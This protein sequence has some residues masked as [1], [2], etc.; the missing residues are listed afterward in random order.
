MQSPAKTYTNSFPGRI[1][2]AILDNMHK[3]IKKIIR[4]RL[5]TDV[6]NEKLSTIEMRYFRGYLIYTRSYTHYPQKKG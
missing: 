3:R 6:V 5:L 4:N 2:Y 1:L